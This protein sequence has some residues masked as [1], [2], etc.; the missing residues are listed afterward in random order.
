MRM[1]K[2]TKTPRVGRSQESTQR[3]SKESECRARRCLRL[4]LYTMYSSQ[5]GSPARPDGKKWKI[6]ISAGRASGKE[7]KMQYLRLAISKQGIR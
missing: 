6:S 1:S 3:E 4:R 7:N 2:N 5:S